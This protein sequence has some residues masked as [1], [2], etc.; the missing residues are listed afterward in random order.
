MELERKQQELK[1]FEILN[2]INDLNHRISP[3][4]KA[5]YLNNHLNYDSYLPLNQNLANDKFSEALST[6]VSPKIYIKSD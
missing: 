2:K 1:K 6:Q 5:T 3:Q 4:K